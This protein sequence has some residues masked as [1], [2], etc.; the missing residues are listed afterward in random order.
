[1]ATKAELAQD[2]TE[3]SRLLTLARN[4]LRQGDIGQAI[5]FAVSSWPRIDG[6]MQFER[7][8]SA[9]EFDTVETIEIVLK[10]APFIFDKQSL[11]SLEEL[12]TEK[13]R[14]EKNTHD[15]LAEKLA[16]ARR[17]M[18]DARRLWNHIERQPNCRQDE[19]RSALQGNQ[20][21]WRGFAECWHSIGLLQRTPESNSYRLAFVTNLEDQ[22]AAKCP[23]CGVVG[24]ARKARLLD[25]ASC[26]KC[27]QNVHFLIVA[28]P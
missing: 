27:K 3:Y 2:C 17:L 10:Y 12:L 8:Y 13:K 18:W 1:M 6:M 7:K 20:E 23:A 21:Q 4:A 9:R 25:A 28:S 15:D 22:A 19:L 14:I 26:P 11:D 16:E 5:G 24:R